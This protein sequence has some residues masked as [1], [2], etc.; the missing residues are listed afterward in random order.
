M[1]Y[2]VN[3]PEMDTADG[4]AGPGPAGYGED[5]AGFP[6][7]RSRLAPPSGKVSRRT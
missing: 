3:L 1:L 4:G 2:E 6:R 5:Q 7:M